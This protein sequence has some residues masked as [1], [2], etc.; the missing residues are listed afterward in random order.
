MQV[1]TE[2]VAAFIETLPQRERFLIAYSGGLD[3]HVLLHLMAS[4]SREGG[5][6]IRAAHVNHNIQPQSRSWAEHCREVCR[7]L[8]VEL[9]ALEVDAGAP[10]KES[11]EG[12]ARDKR[13]AALE[14]VLAEGEILLT[15]HHSDDQLETFL[16]RLLRGAGVLGLA[17]MRSVRRFGSGLHARPLLN[18][19]RAQLL[20]YAEHH[21]LDWIEDPS[22]TDLHADRNYLR[23][24]VIP[25]IKH[26]WPG[27]MLPVGRT[28]ETLAETQALLDDLA[29]QDLLL[30]RAEDPAVVHIERVQQLPAPRQKNMIRYWCRLL[31]LP[32]P[33]SRRLLQVLTGI[34]GARHDSMPCVRWQ[35]AEMRRHRQ[36]LYLGAPLQE[37]DR[38]AIRVWDFSAPC[39]LQDGE[40]SARAGRGN[41]LRQQACAG[42]RVEIR[43]RAGGEK[44]RLP[45]RD[46]THKLKKLF[47]Q[48]GTPPWLRE[49]VP[50]IYVDGRLAM[51]AGFWTDAEF[52]AAADEPSWV[53]TWSARAR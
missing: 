37:I 17:S 20:A 43:Y 12:W 15:A 42:S 30:C 25:A 9:E 7:A 39:R 31:A 51:V 48:A 44:I 5:Y 23:H 34:I 22:N 24:E 33:D 26:R 46:C 11:P 3:S 1:S 35:G 49:R 16:L 47:Q 6:R 45:G 40:L 21:G 18:F 8:E 4:L 27:V 29:R 10:G 19:S 14:N 52:I 13:Y 2:S 41:G 32:S 53:I 38:S 36:Y 28:I 50:L